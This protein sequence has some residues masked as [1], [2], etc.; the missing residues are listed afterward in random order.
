[1]RF[2]SISLPDRFIRSIAQ[3]IEVM[4]EPFTPLAEASGMGQEAWLELVK[5]LVKTGLIR[6]FGAI[7]NHYKAGVKANVMVAWRVPEEDIERVGE[8]IA[9]FRFVTH[10][11]ERPPLPDFPYNLYSMI[12]GATWE[13]CDKAICEISERTGISEYLPLRTIREFKKSSPPLGSEIAGDE[14]TGSEG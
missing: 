1:M 14:Q 6:R 11:Y 4:R 13:E 3:G 2:P 7:L 9:S 10:C 12:H 5:G 8:S